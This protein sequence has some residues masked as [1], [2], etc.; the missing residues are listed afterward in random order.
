M[1]SPRLLSLLA[2]LATAA[3]IGCGGD[4]GTSADDARTAYESVQSRLQNL[5]QDVG[6]QLQAAQSQTNERLERAFDQ[7]QQRADEA[8]AQLRDLDV[9]DDLA[10][11]RDAL[12]DAVARGRDALGDVV[13]AVRGADA[14]AAGEAA[15]QLVEDSDAIRRAREQFEQALDAATR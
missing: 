1:R 15:Q 8:T 5:G 12:R 4:D 13:D 10:D 7:L 6:R 11:E 2:V 14:Q 3:L 9:P